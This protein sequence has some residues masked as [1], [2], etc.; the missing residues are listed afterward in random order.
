LPPRRLKVTALIAFRARRSCGRL[1]PFAAPRS[2]VA[3]G[4][5]ADLVPATD[6]NIAPAGDTAPAGDP[7]DAIVSLGLPTNVDTLIVDGRILR[8]AGKFTAFDHDKIVAEAR[9]AAIRL[10]DKANWPT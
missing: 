1:I 3:P 4:K 2:L 6:I 5:R 9:E 7:Y 8:R 10:R